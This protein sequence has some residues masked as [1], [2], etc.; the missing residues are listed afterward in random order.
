MNELTAV[1]AYVVAAVLQVTVKASGPV[2][3]VTVVPV[4]EAL[5]ILSGVA[6]LYVCKF[7]AAVNVVEFM[8]LT[9]PSIQTP[10]LV[11]AV[12]GMAEPSVPDTADTI[13]VLPQFSATVSTLLVA[14]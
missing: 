8:Q 2:A 13:T 11:N 4:V 6:A 10:F 14:A 9:R 7:S 5:A 3:P 1:N 12:A